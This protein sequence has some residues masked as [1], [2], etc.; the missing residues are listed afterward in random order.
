MEYYKVVN[1]THFNGMNDAHNFGSFQFYQ[2]DA[3]KNE[4]RVNMQLDLTSTRV[5]P[6]WCQYIYHSILK[7]VDPKI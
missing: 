1:E 2:A 3:T 4:Y 6:Y 5:V 7:T